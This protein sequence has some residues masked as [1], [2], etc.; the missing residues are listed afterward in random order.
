MCARACVNMVLCCERLFIDAPTCLHMLYFVRHII[1]GQAC[2]TEPEETTTGRSFAIA[3][4]T[5]NVVDFHW[6]TSTVRS[7]VC[8]VFHKLMYCDCRA[9]NRMKIATAQLQTPPKNSM[10]MSKAFIIY[11]TRLCQPVICGSVLVASVLALTHANG[12]TQPSKM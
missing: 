8:G 4:R 9:Q 5:P 3:S 12:K 6:I 7:V 10:R 1:P 11:A 2:A